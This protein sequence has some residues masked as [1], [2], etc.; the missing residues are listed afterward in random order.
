MEWQ[1]WSPQAAIR[2]L[3]FS[4]MEASGTWAC[5]RVYTLNHFSLL[6]KDMETLSRSQTSAESQAGPFSTSHPRVLLDLPLWTTYLSCTN[7]VKMVQRGKF[8]YL[9]PVLLYHYLE[10]RG[11][12]YNFWC[13]LMYWCV[14]TCT[15]P[16]WTLVVSHM[17]A[18]K[19]CHV[20]SSPC[21]VIDW[22]RLLYKPWFLALV[23][24]F[25][26]HT[27]LRKLHTLYVP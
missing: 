7:H 17:Y 14:S 26:N 20:L 19:T 6:L 1:K 5:T 15:S 12:E 25:I 4:A 24:L 22:D 11:H 8:I 2:W 10:K 18:W 3:A 16:S 27:V 13:C 9:L 23:Q 21:K